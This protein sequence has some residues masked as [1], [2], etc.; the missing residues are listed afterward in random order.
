MASRSSKP[1]AGIVRSIAPVGPFIDERIAAFRE[2]SEALAKDKRQV[3]IRHAELQGLDP[4]SHILDLKICDPAMG[5]GHFL[6]SLVD[7]LADRVLAAMA[8]ATA[9]VTFSTY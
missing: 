9:I 3:E 4:A 6:V 2:R 7:W 8:E 5:S 1:S